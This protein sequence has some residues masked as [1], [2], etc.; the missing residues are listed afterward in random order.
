MFINLFIQLILSRYKNIR[1]KQNKTT[2]QSRT[3]DFETHTQ[4]DKNTIDLI[5]S[6]KSS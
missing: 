5:V 2:K 6:I 1:N 4:N 3:T